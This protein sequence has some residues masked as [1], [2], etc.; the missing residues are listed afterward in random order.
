MIEATLDKQRDKVGGER[1]REW[2]H[3]NASDELRVSGDTFIHAVY[4]IRDK[5]KETK[6]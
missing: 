3:R 6:F 4:F 2:V 5:P 1:R